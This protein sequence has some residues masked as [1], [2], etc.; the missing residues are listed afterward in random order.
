MAAVT[1]C[2][3]AL[4]LGPLYHKILRPPLM[5]ISFSRPRKSKNLNEGPRKSWEIR[6]HF[7]RLVNADVK[8]WR[9]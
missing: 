9:M 2:E 6:F 8:V 1:S 4:S 7:G 5:T 3:N